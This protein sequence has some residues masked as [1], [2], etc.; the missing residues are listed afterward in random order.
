M[1]RP[2]RARTVSFSPDV[3]YFKPAGV[4]MSALEHI[5][6]TIEEL[7]AIRL[8]DLLGLDQETAAKKMK[9][10][11]P[12]FHRILGTARKKVTQALV[13]GNSIRIEGGNFKMAVPRGRGKMSGIRPVPRA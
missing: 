9:V 8:K 13:N 5:V 2:K 10:S 3:T 4:P 11:Q 12:T 6:L 1:P 7:E